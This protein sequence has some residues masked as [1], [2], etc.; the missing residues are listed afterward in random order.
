VKKFQNWS[1]HDNRRGA[2]ATIFLSTF[3]IMKHISILLV[4]GATLNS[5]DSTRQLFMRA[6][7]VLAYS[8]QPPKFV[9]ELIGAE[10]QVEFSN[11]LYT[12]RAD[13]TLDELDKTN[14]IV[15]P[16]ICGDMDSI[17]KEN[18]SYYPWLNEQHKNGSEIASLCVGAYLLAATG[19]LDGRNCTVHWASV[20]DFKARFPKVKVEDTRIITDES[21]LY[22]S[23]GN[24]SYLNLILY[25]IEKYVNRETA[26]LISKMFEIEIERNTQA[27]YMIFMGQKNHKDEAIK[28]VQ[29]YIE[30]NYSQKITTDLLSDMF[31]ISRR[32][33]ERRF[34]TSTGNSILKYLQ[35]V[36]VEAVKKGIEAN[37]KPMT[38]IIN[39]V[40]FVDVKSFRELFKRITGLSPADYRDKYAKRPTATKFNNPSRRSS[41]H[42]SP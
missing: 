42:L 1:K 8:G 40:G 25:L 38:D 23:G 13:K 37:R 15:I 11:K 29:D 12:V 16:L 39:D 41:E 33:I 32:M 24:F 10:R 7:D 20:Y 30:H 6:N 31:A 2:F 27:P 35:R 34:K 21:G 17:I 36:K 3:T 18:A 9:V 4:K 19:L 5:I 28:K 26:V 14:L 22:T